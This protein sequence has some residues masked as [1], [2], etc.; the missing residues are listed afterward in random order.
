VSLRHQLGAALGSYA[1]G[2]I[3]HLTGNYAGFFT[4]AAILAGAGA[5]L[6]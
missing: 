2:L 5:G 3:H 1:G 6:A 4:G